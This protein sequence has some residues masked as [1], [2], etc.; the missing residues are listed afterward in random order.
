MSKRNVSA[1]D[2]ATAEVIRHYLASAA[3]E[4]ERTLVRT[5][6][7][8]I[9]YEINDFGLS[10]FD[11]NLN[12]LADATGLPLFLGANEYAIRQ[13]LKN[14]Q[15]GPMEPGDV[16]YMNVPYWSGAHTNDGVLVSPVFVDGTIAAYTVARA[17]WTAMGGKDPGYILDST[18]VH[19]EGVM[20]P[21]EK[22]VRRG[23]PNEELLRIIRV[24]SRA[25]ETVMGDFNAEVACLRT[26]VA[27]IGELYEKYGTSTVEASIERILAA[28]EEQ[29]RAAVR[30]MP[31]GEWEAE[32]W[33]DNDGV[34]DD[35]VRVHVR[36]A[37]E[38]D[39]M[40]ID[41]S[42]SSQ[43]VE[44][45]I[46]LSLGMARSAARICFK[47]LTT[48]NEP[49]NG[50]QFRPLSIVAPEGNL[51]NAAYPSPVFTIWAGV[52]A[53]ETIYKALAQAVPERMWAGSGGDLGD[54]GFYGKEPYTGRQI[55][56]QTNAGVGWGA[57]IDRD[58]INTTQHVSMCTV[59]NIP[60][61]VVEARL[62]VMVDRAGF[63][64][65][66]GGPGRFRGGLG[67][68][69]DY[70]FL[71]P[72]GALTILKKSR[73]PGWGLAGGKPGPLNLS[74]LIPNTERPD[75]KEHFDRDIISYAD[76]AY[77]Y[78]DKPEDVLYCGMFRGEFGPGD[79]ISYLADGG[80]G[81]GDPF[82]RD[83]ERVR[84]DVIDGYV[85]HTAAEREYGVVLTDKLEIDWDATKRLRSAPRPACS[86]PP[87]RRPPPKKPRRR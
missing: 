52:S 46:N 71:A 33:M 18:T 15:C 2:P 39:N 37:I 57:R 11:R 79:V 27:R 70:R 42:G 55:W 31:D 76:N 84:A 82:T 34:N 38:G 36:V 78:D 81:Y 51:F 40:T 23:E 10:I 53:V 16:L 24:N 32:D 29:A 67:S 6:Y 26:G 68:V 54:P 20:I 62:P 85:S 43:K 3:T 28:G 80:G 72:F 8:T 12:L 47:S 44:G 14:C 19:Q 1:T 45:P 75:W 58:G 66:S 83:P 60:V 86:E 50:G 17:H 87:I 4:M 35:L 48:P 73:T 74:I 63:R 13:A 21:G 69:R 41:Y 61:E 56:H 7:S 22:I 30:A 65:D 77:L 9:I 64:Q 49:S 59:K 25:P 5:A